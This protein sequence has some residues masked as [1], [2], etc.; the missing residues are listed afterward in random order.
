M[1]RGRG[2]EERT[3]KA[4]DKEIAPYFGDDLL[5]KKERGGETNFLN[6]VEE[7]SC[8]GTKKFEKKEIKINQ[9]KPN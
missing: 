5:P 2:K 7:V 1:A 8:S 6:L 9:T 4:V 3:C